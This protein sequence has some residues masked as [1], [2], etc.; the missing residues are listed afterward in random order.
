[1]SFPPPPPGPGQDPNQ[2]FN[3]QPWGA[4]PPP[5]PF[6]PQQ[7]GAP[8]YGA[9]QYGGGFQPQFNPQ[10]GDP[11]TLDLPW[12][13]IGAVDAIKRMFQKYARFDGRA[14]RGEYWWPALA[15]FLV[16]IVLNVLEGAASLAGSTA[17]YAL[18]ALVGFVFALGVLVPGLALGARRL[19]DAGFSAW[20][21]LLIL[22]IFVGWIAL[23]VLLCLPSKP[24]GAKYDRVVGAPGGYY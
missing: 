14:S 21:L 17:L 13:G 8:Q 1:M 20:L 4:P 23:L 15:Y 16:S 24:E 5:Q 2:Q 18:L 7:Y 12:Y 11:G 19:H 22:A 9:P 6:P 3:P 10:Q